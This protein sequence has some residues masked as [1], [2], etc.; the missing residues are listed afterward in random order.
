[1]KQFEFY[2]LTAII[3]PGTLFI[4]GI[5][6]VSPEIAVYFQKPTFGIGDWGIL[7]IIAYGI[8]HLIQGVGNFLEDVYW[9]ILGG[10]PTDW[11][12]TNK[13]YLL[14][15]GLRLELE[16]CLSKEL[17]KEGT[18]KISALKKDAWESIVNLINNRVKNSDYYQRVYKFNGNYGLM[19][20]IAA[21]VLILIC[22]TLLSSPTIKKETIYLVVVF[23]LSIWRMHRFGNYFAR[24][25]FVSYINLNRR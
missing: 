23:A 14:S 8:G 10:K 22:I 6:L 4:I 7:V 3:V 25:L 19:R 16:S 24:E 1:M 11:I 12:R 20:G 18:Q 13:H 5:S 15:D 9:T 17:E 2:E 21:S